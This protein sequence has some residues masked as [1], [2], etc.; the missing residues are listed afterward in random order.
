MQ[1]ND[2]DNVRVE[3][4]PWGIFNLVWD[5]LL[6]NVL[7]THYLIYNKYCFFLYM[8]SSRASQPITLF[9]LNSHMKSVRNNI[10]KISIVMFL[11]NMILFKKNCVEKFEKI[12]LKTLKKGLVYL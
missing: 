8:P 1:L 4:E 5:P 2:F 6:I 3:K 10:N 11:V 9:W 12:N 7:I